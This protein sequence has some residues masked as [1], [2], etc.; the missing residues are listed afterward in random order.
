[1]FGARSPDW[2]TMSKEDLVWEARANSDPEKRKVLGKMDKLSAM[3]EEGTGI[4]Y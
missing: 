3:A 2:P 4:W 1:M